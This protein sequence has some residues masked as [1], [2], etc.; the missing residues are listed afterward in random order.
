MPAPRLAT[1]DGTLESDGQSGT[2]RS[3][4]HT[5]PLP[6]WL[7]TVMT[8]VGGGASLKI[9]ELA[10]ARFNKKDEL[11]AQLRKELRDENVALKAEIDKLEAALAAKR[12]EMEMFMQR[13]ARALAAAEAVSAENRAL[14]ERNVELMQQNSALVAQN[15]SLIAQNGQLSAEGAT[16]AS[17]LR[18]LQ[19]WFD[20]IRAKNRETG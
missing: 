13:N 5:M 3:E 17:D 11:D 19:L 18:A 7:Q 1:D 10:V 20:A 6:D 12:G 8:L 9:G 14:R 15:R 16:L 2:R 4:G